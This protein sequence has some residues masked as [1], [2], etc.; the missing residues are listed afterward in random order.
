MSGKSNNPEYGRPSVALIT[1]R[2]DLV[3]LLAE[4]L[5]NKLC[6]VQIISDQYSHRQKLAMPKDTV[7]FVSFHDIESISKGKV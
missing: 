1:D 4:K 5:I 3:P 7:P 6:A 2:N